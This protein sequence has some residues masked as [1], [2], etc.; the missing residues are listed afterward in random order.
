MSATGILRISKLLRKRPIV[1][2]R[3]S[4]NVLEKEKV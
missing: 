4:R 3:K 1:S 2:G